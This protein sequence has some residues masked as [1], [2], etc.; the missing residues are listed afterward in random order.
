LD[1]EFALEQMLESLRSS[2]NPEVVFDSA[3]LFEEA[4]MFLQGREQWQAAIHAEPS[5]SWRRE[6]DERGRKLEERLQAREQRIHDLTA[7]PASYLAHAD[8]AQD[9]IELVMG[10]ALESWL[11]VTGSP[12]VQKALNRLASELEDQHHD[13]WLKELIQE[14][15]LPSNKLA[16]QK[17]SDAWKANVRGEP[18]SAASD[19]VDAMKRFGTANPAGRLRA[20]QEAAYAFDRNWEYD[21]CLNI[22]SNRRK[23]APIPLIVPF[24][25][26]KD[27]PVQLMVPSSTRKEAQARHYVWIEQQSWLEE[28]SCYTEM[29]KKDVIPDR[30]VAYDIIAKGHYESLRLRALSFLTENYGGVDSRV[31]IWKSGQDGLKSF[32]KWTLP[33]NRGYTF[34]Y[35]LAF[36]AQQAGNT[37]AAG[38]LLREG[39]RIMK[40]SPYRQLY[41]LAL[42]DLGT[43]ET[44]QGLL[45][46]AAQTFDAME[47]VFNHL[48]A[49]EIKKF[50]RQ[51]EISRAEADLAMG[52]TASA[53]LL[54]QPFMK[55]IDFAP[56]ER[57]HFLIVLGNACLAAGNH[58]SA[59]EYYEEIIAGK[60]SEIQTVHNRTQRDSSLHEIEPAWRGL[61]NIN[62]REGEP[63]AAFHT[64]ESMRGGRLHDPNS[65]LAPPP[66]G[67]ALLVYAFLPDGLSGWL[68]KNDSIEQHWLDGRSALKDS[69]QFAAMLADPDSP[70]EDVK[71]VG[72]RLYENLLGPFAA[73][74]PQYGLLV[75]D[76]DRQLAGITWSALQ[77]AAGEALVERFAISQA[78][79]WAEVSSQITHSGID[80]SH[81]LI[82]ADPDLDPDLRQQYPPLIEARLEAERLQTEFRKPTY[83]IG[84][85]ASGEALHHYLPR[86]SIFHSA[87]H[88]ISYGAFGALLL[89]PGP[90]SLS[91]TGVVTAEQ[92]R[93]MKLSKLDLV[94][95][96]S[97]SSGVGEQSG[98]VNLDSLVRSF[99]DAGAKRVIAA[100][101]NV[102]SPA[103]AVLMT[104]FYKTLIQQRQRPAEALRSAALTL[105]RNPKY[106]HPYYWAGFQVFGS[107]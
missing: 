95:L 27:A 40:D 9:S 24:D 59:K 106:A 57:Q 90:G 85:Q 100:R 12:D 7:S 96:A 46:E 71:A 39:V 22:L 21:I 64:W 58:G 30:Q 82:L 101:W 75:I 29:R 47:D 36:S 86:A 97:C 8:E 4:Q 67:V 3:L 65:A 66:A 11:P 78:V 2:R 87:S 26:H 62:I 32:W 13:P 17:L 84:A 69:E 16:I 68:V 72:Q 37:Q 34:C 18:L 81:A 105:R 55:D 45:K 51:A 79:G 103:T 23:D 88:G 5:G 104:E 53:L 35:T 25:P 94:V 19:A 77:N 20:R 15:S 31:Q 56:A 43:W 50:R 98:V 63:S 38:A 61:A 107:P 80:L 10:K 14:A 91:S 44:K 52:D 74:L 102:N 99:L 92:I 6:A 83:L 60:I 49:A 70:P 54:L 42:S 28:T 33:A 73:S 41:A 1:Y 48:D 89:A 93:G 76:A